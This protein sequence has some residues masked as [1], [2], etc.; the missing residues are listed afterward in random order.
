VYDGLALPKRK[1]I[2]RLFVSLLLLLVPVSLYAQAKP[3]SNPMED[4][5][6]PGGKFSQAP[7]EIT[8]EGQTHYEGGIAIAQNHVVIHYGDV[9]IY[10][11][12]AEYNTDT[13]D[14]FVKERVRLYRGDYAFVCDR[15]VYNL[16]TKR[17]YM[18]DFAGSKLPFEIT[19]TNLTSFSSDEYQIYDGSFTTSDTSQ[20]D[21]HIQAKGIR[22]YPNDRIIFTNA[23]V[24]VKDYPVIWFPYLYQ[25]LNNQFLFLISPGYNS[26]YGEYEVSDIGF[27]IFDHFDAILHLNAYTLRGPALGLEVNYNLGEVEQSDTL[28]INSFFLED[29]GANINETSLGRE[30][31]SSGRY[32]ISYDSRTFLASDTSLVLQVNKWSDPYITQDFFPYEFEVDPEP[33]T[34]I[35][36]IK[37]GDAY[38]LS[39]FARYQVNNF[40]QTTEKLPELSWEVVRTPLF[41][42]PI[43]YEATNTAGWDQLAQPKGTFF[44]PDLNPDYASFRIDSFH[45]ITYPN[46][47]FG[48]LSIVPRAGVRVTYYSRTGDVTEG[49]PSLGIPFGSVVY[50]PSGTRL[51]FNTGFDASFKLSHIYEGVQAHWLGLDGLLHVIQPYVDY[52]WVQTPNIGPGKILPYD[53]YITSTY[54]PAIDFPQFTA[55]D[56]IAGMSVMRLGVLNKFETRRDSATFQWLTLDTFFDINYKNPY[57]QTY[58][59]DI[60]EQV[61]FNPVPWLQFTEFAQLPWIEAKQFWEFNTTVTWT[62]TPNIDVT[63]L[64][65]YLNHNP[66]EPKTNSTYLQTYFRIN[67][68]WGFSILEEYDQTTGRLGVQKYTFHRDLSSWIA[69]V[70]LYEDNNGGGKNTYGVELILTL[71]DLPKY[72]FPFNV[73]PGL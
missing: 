18:A 1:M 60:Q 53:R 62:V 42:S 71:K 15:A 37:Q 64:H 24:Y 73:S 32:R 41:N 63:L 12:Y 7:V 69:S 43:Y 2:C 35:E 68:N 57:E 10:C 56:S 6:E 51:V 13:H 45:Q 26:E 20:P 28:H 49:D 54:L 40:F 65:S 8:S 19:G 44:N 22:I 21:Y 5:T 70:G 66:L 59:S 46:T 39:L 4:L 36:L 17:L 29:K 50:Q 30:P 27:P 55:T 67:S 3:S 72:G 47:Y 9:A 61:R 38:A 34:Y 33:Q 14:V 48:F 31:I 52:S 16:E 58:Y 25:S 23:W 11:E